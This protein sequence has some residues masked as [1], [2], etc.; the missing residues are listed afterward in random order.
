MT[1]QKP[2]IKS[3][4]PILVV[5]VVEACLPFWERL[6]FAVTVTVPEAATL[7]FAILARDGMEVMLQSRASVGQDTPGVAETVA[8]SV[9]YLAVEALDPVIAALGDVPVAAPRRTTFY[10]ADE[11]FLRDPAGNVIGFA[12][13]SA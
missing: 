9:L 13:P 5:P 7:D 6:G 10:G 3:L 12:A 8:C 1:I 4:A 11:I 2:V